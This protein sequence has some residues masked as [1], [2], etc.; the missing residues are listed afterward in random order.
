MDGMSDDEIDQPPRSKWL[1]ATLTVQWLTAA[2]AILLP[3]GFDHPS[4]MGLDFGHYLL[5]M[6]LLGSFTLA[7]LL[8]AGIGRDAEGVLY[9]LMPPLAYFF[10]VLNR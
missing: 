5:T 10:F 8:I 6:A 9:G 1:Y 4:S 3:F 2:A 7:S